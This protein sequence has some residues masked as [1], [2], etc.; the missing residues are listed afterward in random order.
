MEV[1]H[2]LSPGMRVGCG[3]S[4]ISNNGGS[5]TVFFTVDGHGTVLL[6]SQDSG[7]TQCD[8]IVL[9]SY[10]MFAG[11]YA[12]CVGLENNDIKVGIMLLSL[13]SC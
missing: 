11:E 5:S 9:S 6:L 10:P 8:S 2:K 7:L 3:V 1:V 12:P 4:P 13:F